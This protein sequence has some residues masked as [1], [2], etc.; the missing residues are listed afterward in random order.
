[1]NQNLRKNRKLNRLESYNYSLSGY[2]FVTFCTKDKIKYFGEIKT[3]QMVLSQYGKIAKYFWQ[4]IPHHYDNIEIDQFI[5]MPNHIHGIII[6]NN[7]GTEQC[8]VPTTTG[9]NYGL[10]SKIIKSFK[11]AVTREIRQNFNDHNFCWQRSFYDHIIR[12]E[13]D[14]ESIYRYIKY[15]YLKNSNS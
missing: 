12:D 9:K 2:Y 8:S 7:V 4:E 5:I 11:N 6:I 10:L 15:N 3:S 14:L 1:M 13:K